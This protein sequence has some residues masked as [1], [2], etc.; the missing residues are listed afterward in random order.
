MTV[1]ASLKQ[2]FIP[3][4]SDGRASD[5][6]TFRSYSDD[7]RV[8]EAWAIALQKRID[9]F[10]PPGVS[11]ITS[12]DHTVNITN[13]TGPTTDLTTPGGGNV[14]AITSPLGSLTVDSST[15]AHP[16]LDVRGFPYPSWTDSRG[17]TGYGSQVLQNLTS[18]SGNTNNTIF[19][20]QAGVQSTT[21]AA[22]TAAGYQS[23]LQSYTGV[24]NVAMGYQALASLSHPGDNSSYNVA[25]GYQAFADAYNAT[26]N[27]VIG[28]QALYNG[29]V[30]SVLNNNTGVVAVG[31]QTLLSCTGNNN[32][33]LGYQAAS[34]P[35]SIGGGIR[36]T[37]IG[38]STHVST[39]NISNCTCIGYNTR[40]GS[41]GGVAIGTDHL[42]NGA[43][44]LNEDYFCLGTVNHVIQISNNATGAGSASLGA[45]CPGI[46]PAQPNAWFHM[47]A[48][49]GTDVY[50]P[51]WV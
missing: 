3:H 23:L 38:A 42:G 13:P 36:N 47:R 15:P 40:G 7:C 8:I 1:L 33:A 48:G 50:V 24:S 43:S 44:T 19:G 4:K 29:T 46:T 37:F 20:Y 6:L 26:N 18:A 28:Y 14:N 25:I 30:G 35:S 49:D 9:N 32:T 41:N 31:Y 21:G 17:N 12:V 5:P 22:N 16:V 39:A 10:Q 2:L 45:N 27:V 11:H 34:S 51:A